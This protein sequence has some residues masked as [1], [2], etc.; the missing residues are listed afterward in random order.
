MG[1][2]V[3]EKY[4]SIVKPALQ[5]IYTVLEKNRQALS[6]AAMGAGV[7]ALVPGSQMLLDGYSGAKPGLISGTAD[8]ALGAVTGNLAGLG[9]AGA[10]T[11]GVMR[12]RHAAGLRAQQALADILH[13]AEVDAP[14][15]LSNFLGDSVSGEGMNR[16]VLGHLRKIRSQGD[17]ALSTEAYKLNDLLRATGSEGLNLREILSKVVNKPADLETSMARSLHGYLG[18]EGPISRQVGSLIGN[19]TETS[20][21]TYHPGSVVKRNIPGF[22]VNKALPFSDKLPSAISKHLP[23]P[24]AFAESYQKHINPAALRTLS[25]IPTLVAALGIVPAALLANRLQHQATGQ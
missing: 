17:A 13:P 10:G 18:K 8:K 5:E 22:A 6:G 21:T 12:N 23:S 11:Y 24:M 1:N 15:R 7:G 20:L 16:S 19:P 3:S 25:R 14:K 9:V 2:D 4:A